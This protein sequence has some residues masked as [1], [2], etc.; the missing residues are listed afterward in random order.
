VNAVDT[1]G[2]KHKVRGLLPNTITKIMTHIRKPRATGF[3]LIELL[4]VIAIIAILASLL[5][6]ALAKA[7]AKAQ[8]ISCVNN[9][10]QVGLSHRLFSND[11]DD[12]Y[13]FS[14][15]QASGGVS[16]LNGGNPLA[17]QIYQSLSNDLNTPKIL[18]CNSDGSKVK[19]SD[20]LNT[21]AIS[22]G[23]QTPPETG[24]SYFAG[25]DAEETKPQSMLSGDRNLQGGL[26]KNW[27]YA[28][29][30]NNGQ[31][32]N[33]NWET[34]LH[35]NAGNVGLGDGSVQQLNQAS[36]KKQIASALEGPG[37]EVRLR[38]P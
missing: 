33:E 38:Y 4:V 7:K 25:I 12:K 34:T 18:V 1:N 17:W 10:K 2:E 23:R 30:Y 31:G 35:N 11:H 5:L 26:P 28:A 9:L 37:G 27:T 16:D 13:T 24:L 14:V 36:L 19:A 8:R 21:T 20:F 22:F 3:T 29:N 15:A 6:P 32:P